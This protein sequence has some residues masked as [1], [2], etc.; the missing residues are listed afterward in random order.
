MLLLGALGVHGAGPGGES[1]PRKRGE[2]GEEGELG[3]HVPPGPFHTFFPTVFPTKKLC[4]QEAL[5][6]DSTDAAAWNNLGAEGGGT[7][8][9]KSYTRKEC[10]EESLKH[11]ST[12]AL[13]WFFL[14]VDGGGTV[15]V[16]EVT[17]V[18]SYSVR[19]SWTRDSQYSITA[20]V[21]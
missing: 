6:N 13:A 9:G 5:Q 12:T 19:S 3:P 11:D 14:G 10:Y 8:G 20:P 7:V 1:A 4:Y 2:W 21:S 17:R 16:H 15:D 18:R